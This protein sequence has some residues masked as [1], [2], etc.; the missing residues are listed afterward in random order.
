VILLAVAAFSL[1]GLVMLVDELHFHRERG[2]P[3]W[4]RWGHPLDTASLFA[5]FTLA[6]VCDPGPSAL[7]VYG[8]LAV[9]SCLCVTKDEFVHAARCRGAEHWLHAVLFLLHPV[10]L[11]FGAL[12]WLENQLWLLRLQAALT[13]CFGV[14]Q[15]FYWNTPWLRAYRI[16]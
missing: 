11:A 14:Y 15:V 9:A 1:Q 7:I 8:A 16:R 10:V 6:L 5:C 12:L 2:L 3:R 4:E 13:L